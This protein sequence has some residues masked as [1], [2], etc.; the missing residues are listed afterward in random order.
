LLIEGAIHHLDIIAD[1]AGARCDSL[2]ATTWKP[3]WAEYAGDTDGIVTMVFENGVHALYE[4]SV[5]HSTGLNTF[6]KEYIR[7]D[8]ENGTAILARTAHIL[9]QYDVA[10]KFYDQQVELATKLKSGPKMLTAYENLIDMY[11]DA[12]RYQEAIDKCESIMDMRGPKE[13]EDAK[14][15]ILERIIQATAKQG[16]VDEALNMTKN[17][18]QAT[19]NSW[20]FLRLRGLIEREGGKID[21][22]IT[23]FTDVLDKLDAAKEIKGDA[24][25]KPA[26]SKGYQFRRKLFT[27]NI[28]WDPALRKANQWYDRIAAVLRIK[29]RTEREKQLAELS[30]EL[31]TLK[32]TAGPGALSTL[33][34][35]P[36]KTETEMGE[37]VGDVLIAMMLPAFYKVQQSADRSEQTQRNLH[38]AFAL[39]AY[40]HDHGKYPNELADL[41]PKYLP[42][43]PED[44][45]SGK[46]LIYRPAENGYLLYSVGPNGKDDGG[47]ARDDEPPGDDLSI[48]IPQPELKLKK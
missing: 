19:D 35:D 9:K 20:Y 11:F 22:A 16:K 45:F 40:R 46:G 14:P 26:P 41:M 7:V 3:S 12:K 21:T 1:L 33:L 39:A 38:L 32:T 27:G 24:K 10:E 48:R 8:G 5:S 2:F 43:I 34:A 30:H 28:D 23:T 29:E 15:F 36:D 37:E 44:L 6:Y 13:I 18:L 25:D 42:Q 31:T 4:G 47:R 17:I